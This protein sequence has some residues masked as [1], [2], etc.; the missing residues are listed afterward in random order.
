MATKFVSTDGS[1]SEKSKSGDT[2]AASKYGSYPNKVT[3]AKSMPSNTQKP[4]AG[5]LVRYCFS[6][7]LLLWKNLWTRRRSHG[8]ARLESVSRSGVSEH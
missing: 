6:N 1:Y 4:K 2:Q 7:I 8:A 5:G 3:P